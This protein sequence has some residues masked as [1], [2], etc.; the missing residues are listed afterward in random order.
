[1]FGFLFGFACLIGL[2]VVLRNDPH[3]NRRGWGGGWHSGRHG[4]WHG[5]WHKG[6]GQNPFIRN[7]FMKLDTTPGQE[8]AI[9][10]AL[11]G[12]FNTMKTSK[13][14]LMS[15]RNDLAAV[16]R[17]ESFDETSLGAVIARHDEVVEGVRTS[18][19]DTLA[20]IYQALDQQQREEVAK[21]LESGSPMP[22]GGPYRTSGSEA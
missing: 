15:S 14:S 18:A 7:L 9:R 2:I 1:M 12:F 17:S 11:D 13:Q 20:D 19:V 16:F 8:K 5:G 3:L 6:I 10:Q 21:W 22:Q 4:H